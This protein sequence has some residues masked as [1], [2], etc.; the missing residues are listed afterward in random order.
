[1][2]DTLL[3]QA[4]VYLA[5]AVICV[6]L[7]SRLGL[8]SVLGYLIAG[9]LIGPSVMQLAGHG[10]HVMHFAEFGVVMM[11]FLVGLELQ[12]SLLWSLRKPIF[13]LG[14][15]Q[16]GGTIAA[17]TLIAIALHVPWR[18]AV[19]VGCIFAMSSTAI[20]LQSLGERGLLKTTGGQASFSVLLFQDLSVILILAVFPLLSAAGVEKAVVHEAGE[21]A[22]PGW[23][24]AIY[25]LGAVA[26]VVLVGRF[27]VRPLFRVIARTRLREIFTAT[28]LLLVIAIAWLMTV[29]GLSPALGTFLAGVVL[30]DSE[31]RHELEGDIEPFKGLLLGLFFMSVGSQIDFQLL[32]HRPLFIAALLVGVM[33]VKLGV[34]FA[35]GRVFKLDRSAR[36]LTA[37]GLCQVG[38][39]AFVL[40]NVGIG[41]H[42][43]GAEVSGPL[44][45]VIALSMLATPPLFLLLQRV[46]LPRVAAKSA[47]RP[48]DEIEHHD[49][50]IV[51][52]GFGRVGQVVGRILRMAGH[53]LTVLDLDP[54]AV[55]LLRRLGQKVYY[56]DA[57]RL[58]LLVAAGL[59]NAKLFVLAIDDPEK[60]VEVAALVRR[61]C[62]SLPILARARNR[63]HYYQLRKLGVV[64]VFRETL[65]T[66]VEMAG[67][68]LRKLGARAHT[69]HRAGLKFRRHDQRVIEAMMEFAGKGEDV[70]MPEAKKM[71]ANVEEAMRSEMR[72]KDGNIDLGWNNDSLRAAARAGGLDEESDEK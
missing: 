5:G 20:V 21:P 69:V 2:S 33:L 47:E 37:V 18:V 6:P 3:F 53:S 48:H 58:D 46:I 59:P 66:S 50:A 26:L 56:G 23:L 70:W 1:V 39:F 9:V 41:E 32:L 13:G 52:A 27:V 19:A 22:R 29:V 25:I 8:G 51:M 67:T 55:D 60:S 7:A 17:V 64:D 72:D 42:V 45:A 44:V 62:P 4:L 65:G 35:L 71:I 36:W 49:A 11:L 38:E 15:L 43:F 28:A 14:G 68:A 63:Q 54:D 34:L 24:Q 30:A 31:Y 57:S 16:V 40:I 12:P 10:T 61:H